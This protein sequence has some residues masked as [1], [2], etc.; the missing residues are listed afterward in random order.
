MFIAGT[1][2]VFETKV[3]SAFIVC[4]AQT[5]GNVEKRSQKQQTSFQDHSGSAGDDGEENQDEVFVQFNMKTVKT[6][7]SGLFPTPE[8]ETQTSTH[9]CL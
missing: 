8:A 9:S 1:G 4:G 3:N 6:H 5:G 7:I 2:V